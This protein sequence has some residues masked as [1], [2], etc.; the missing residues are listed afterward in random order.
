MLIF[1]VCFFSAYL[2]DSSSYF[3][4]YFSSTFFWFCFH[5]LNS[6]YTCFRQLGY[7]ILCSLRSC[8]FSSKFF[9]FFRLD[10]FLLSSFKIHC[11]L[12]PAKRQIDWIFWLWRFNFPILSLF[13]FLNIAFH[14]STEIILIY[15][16]CDHP[17]L[18]SLKLYNRYFK[19]VVFLHLNSE[20]SCGCCC[21]C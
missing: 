15:V 5:S 11:H 4:K 18:D 3:F 21:G 17:F 13:R 6:S 19:D 9:M 20:S 1:S 10:Y 12:Q 7:A 8:L 14:F 16:H 2:G